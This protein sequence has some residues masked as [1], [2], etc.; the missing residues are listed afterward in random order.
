MESG[1]IQVNFID[2]GKYFVYFTNKNQKNRILLSLKENSKKIY[3]C[4]ILRNGITSV[5]DFEIVVK[6]R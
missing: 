6:N 2:G 1:I 5:K 4:G 3:E